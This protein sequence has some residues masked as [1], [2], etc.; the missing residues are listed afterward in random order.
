MNNV[1]CETTITINTAC[2]QMGF[3]LEITK[4]SIKMYAERNE[5][6]HTDFEYFTTT[7]EFTQY[8]KVLHDD[9]RSIYCTFS[10]T[11]SPIDRQYLAQI[12]Q[13]EIDRLFDT[14]LNPEAPATWIPK[15]CLMEAYRKANEKKGER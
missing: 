11:R 1:P 9:L 2:E 8:A 7:G 5:A 3:D 6:F 4:W 15:Y 13:G 10:A 12:I 14:R